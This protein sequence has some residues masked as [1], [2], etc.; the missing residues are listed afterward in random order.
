MKLTRHNGRAGKNGA[1]NP[2]HND[3]RFDVANS[4][5]ISEERTKKNIYWDCYTGYSSSLIRQQDKENDYSFEQV[6]RLYYFEHYAD[7]IQ[8]QNERNEKTR[9]TERNRTVDDLL[10]NNK[11]CPEESIYQ[12]GT[13]DESVSGEI[14]AKIANEFFS[15]MEEKYGSHVHILDW[16]LHLDE[17]TPHIHERHVF[18]CKN[19][20][21]EL[22]PQQ[23]KALEE[24]GIPLPDPDKKKGR[25]NNRKQTFDTECRKMLFRICEKNNLHLQKE[26]SYGG[27]AYLEKQ[28]FIIEKQKEVLFEQR[29]ILAGTARAIEEREEKLR[30]AEN[31]ISQR[32]NVIE[33]QDMLIA[34]KNAEIM[35]KHSALEEVTMKLAEV[36]TLADE[37]AEQAY[38]KACEVV[39]DTVR[40]ETRKEDMKILDDYSKWLSAP[41]R[42]DDKKLRNYAVKCLAILKEKFVKS[43]KGINLL[44][45]LDKITKTLQEPEKK[46]EN[47]RQVKEKARESIR[48]RLA[49]G[50]T[51]ADRINQ[52][53]MQCEGKIKL[54]TKKDMEL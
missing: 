13:V 32:E 4:E 51:E 11:T 45:G 36:E 30:Q 2:K 38:E 47:L 10:T 18:D 37:V 43:A 8:A 50:K 23:E 7:H 5:H 48:E 54:I 26:P 24:L 40:A 53:R 6:E 39:A 14:L 44:Q 12:I 52:K 17:G 20:Y 42:I 49:R 27:R 35:E 22:C 46:N 9:H 21:G 15:E 3:R 19:K 28:D 41:E 1:Y 34:E 25:N 29:E 16:A 33:K 31:A